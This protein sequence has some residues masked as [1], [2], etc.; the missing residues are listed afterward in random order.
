MDTLTHALSGA[1]VARLIAARQEAP[2][3]AGVAAPAAGSFTA[4]WTTGAAAPKP[5]QYVVVGLVAGAFPDIDVAARWVSDLAY[6]RHHRGITHSVLM[7]PLWSLGLAW[8]F[9]LAFAVTRGV[10]HGWKSLYVVVAA[11]IAVHI[12]GDWITQFGTML[13]EPLSDA[14]FGLGAI[15]IIDL[16]LSGLVLAGLVLAALWPRRRWPAATALAMVVA[17]VGVSWVGKQEAITAGEAYARAQGMVGAEVEAIPRP[18]SPFNWTVTVRD[19]EQFHVAHLNTR[20]IDPLVATPQDHFIR[21][22]SAPYQPIAQVEWSAV[23]KF[24]HGSE[25]A[26]AR[27]VWSRPEFEFFRWFAQAPVLDRVEIRPVASELREAQQ[28]AW[29][30]DLRFGFPGRDTVPFRYGLCL[31][32]PLEAPTAVAVYKLDEDDQGAR[33]LASGH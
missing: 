19:G 31:S 20:R 17:W 4:P 27:A 33:R 26:V 6:L 2:M 8:L 32:G 25:Q 22:F 18:A 24:G 5:W 12:A 23:P 15:F 30:R 16:T 14:R 11:A 28:C 7:W 9:S 3:A 13:L 29:F 1:L 10:R 21:R